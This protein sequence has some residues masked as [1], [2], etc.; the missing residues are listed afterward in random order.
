M[1]S[2]NFQ[3]D[4]SLQL[5]WN[6]KAEL[7]LPDTIIKL[8]NIFYKDSKSGK[9][10]NYVSPFRIPYL[11][12]A[13]SIRLRIVTENKAD[14]LRA[15]TELT[16]PVKISSFQLDEQKILVHSTNGSLP[17]NRYYG[18]YLEY[19][20]NEEVIRKSEYYDY[21]RVTDQELSFQLNIPPGRR[22]Y[23]VILYHIT[24][25]NYEFQRALQKASRSNVDPFEAPIILP[26]TIKGGQG[27][28]TYT[29]ADTLFIK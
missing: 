21:S 23:R 20:I 3:E 11:M 19:T 27:I 24:A 22:S 29:T 13:D 18:I 14:T 5:I 10:V 28:F 2:S 26:G 1:R 16:T 7:I 4:L 6:A 17:E 8:Q 9:L 15:V 12:M 25:A